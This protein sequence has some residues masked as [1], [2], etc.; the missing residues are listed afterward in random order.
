MLA[1]RRGLHRGDVP[2][3]RRRRQPL[4]RGGDGLHAAHVNA[5]RLLWQVHKWLGIAFGLLLVLSAA[6]G[7]LLLQKK[8]WEWV[9]P[10]TRIGT[11]G[12]PEQMRPLHEVYAAVFAL[13]LPQLRAEADIA[14]IDFRPDRRLH[15]VIAVADHIEVQVDAISL[16]TWGPAT[17]TSD[18][19]E[20]L[21]DGSWFGAFMHDQVMSAVAIA[22]VLLALSGYFLWLWPKWRRR[23]RRA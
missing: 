14:R 19:L 16:R 23:A 13:G 22:C 3:K 15:K 2:A 17:R 7:F 11:E 6:T 20:S 9:Q 1:R 5:F 18:W 10:P 12:S 4:A 21:H 8:R